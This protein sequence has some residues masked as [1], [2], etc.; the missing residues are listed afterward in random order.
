M[1]GMARKKENS[2]AVLRSSPTISPPMFVEAAL[3]TPG[4]REKVLVS[5]DSP[6]LC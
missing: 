3:E 1:M 2:A 4:I 5:Q 6:L